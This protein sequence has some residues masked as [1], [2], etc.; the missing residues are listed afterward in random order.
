MTLSLSDARFLRRLDGKLYLGEGCD[1][2]LEDGT[3]RSVEAGEQ[4]AFV[5]EDGVF[6]PCQVL[7]EET[8]CEEAPLLTARNG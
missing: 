1:L 7:A 5:W 3:L 2:Y 6:R 4:K 8:G